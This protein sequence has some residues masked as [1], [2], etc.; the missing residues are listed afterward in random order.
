[1]YAPASA[2]RPL[3]RPGADVGD[4]PASEEDAVRRGVAVPEA[5]LPGPAGDQRV[6]PLHDVRGWIRFFKG[7]DLILRIRTL[8]TLYKTG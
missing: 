5:Q 1:M 3:Q 4:L 7:P 6:T 8:K 2:A